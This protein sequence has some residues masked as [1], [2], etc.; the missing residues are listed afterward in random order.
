M[1]EYSLYINYKSGHFFLVYYKSSGGSDMA[2]G[3]A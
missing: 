3:R 1:N 2:H